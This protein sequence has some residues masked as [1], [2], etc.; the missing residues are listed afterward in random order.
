MPSNTVHLTFLLFLYCFSLSDFLHC[1]PSFL[2][3]PSFPARS[4]PFS[5]CLL[6]LIHTHKKPTNHFTHFSFLS[7][8]SHF[9]F[10]HNLIPPFLSPL[11]FPFKKIIFLSGLTLFYLFLFLF[12]FCLL[13]SFF[14]SLEFGFGPLE[15][16]NPY[17]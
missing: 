5:V 8:K 9:I 13:L 7:P 15:A 12:L 4:G 17:L 3:S 16:T 6:F 2:P 1:K 10:I 11:H 14:L